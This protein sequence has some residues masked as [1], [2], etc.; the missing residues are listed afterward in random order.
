L[1]VRV[2]SLDRKKFR[3]TCMVM[4]LAPWRLPPLVKL[5]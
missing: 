3:A 4:V 2:F 1:R 5:A